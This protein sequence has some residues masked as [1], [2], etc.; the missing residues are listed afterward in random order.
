MYNY[1]Q[2]KGAEVNYTNHDEFFINKVL[3]TKNGNAISNGIIYQVMCELLDINARIIN[4]PKQ[5]IIA[6]YQ[7]DFDAETYIGNPQEKI[8]FYVDGVNGQAYSHKDIENYF[9]RINVPPTASY[10]KPLSHKRIIQV[11]AEEV[12]KCF[13]LPSNEYKQNELKL[14]ANLL[15]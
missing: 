9:K 6:F 11:L 7:T 1:Y 5:M 8:H 10:Y 3:E 13:D 2:L 4:I 12:A 14:L 15:D